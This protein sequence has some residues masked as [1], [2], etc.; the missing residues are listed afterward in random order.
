MLNTPIRFDPKPLPFYL[1][2]PTRAAEV[3]TP[4]WPRFTPESLSKNAAR[5]AGLPA[6]FPAHVEEALE[7]L[8]RSL[9]DDAHP[10][11]FGKANYSLLL[12]TG[13]CSFLQVEQAFRDNPSL[14]MTPLIPP[15]F[16]IGLPRSGTTFLHRLLSA[17]EDAAGVALYQHVYPVPGRF[18]DLRRADLRLQFEPWKRASRAYQM[19]AMHLVRPE[20]PDECNWGMR[21]GGRSMLFSSVAP[22]YG[23]L[24]WLLDQDLRETYAFYRKVL[25][26]HQHHMP[27]KRLVLKCPH[28]LAWL[29]ALAEAFPE[30]H[31]VETHRDPLETVP[32]ECKLNLSLH[33]L[34]APKLDLRRTVEHTLLKCRTF[35]ERSV[36]FAATPE[37]RRI[38]HVD[39]RLLVKDPVALA[40]DIYAA[41]QLP[42]TERHERTLRAFASAN[43]QHKHGRNS[44]QLE[45]FALDRAD[46]LETFRAYRERFVETL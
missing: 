4:D 24:R 3:L 28:H 34:A 9:R 16:V 20:L 31:I 44:Y 38:H 6:H 14:H 32:S 11:W 15:V 46:I 27:G 13:L 1:Q 8:C 21:L 23:Y 36:A 39:Y 40:R 5:A 22:V 26:L 41:L 2:I 43:K 37:G 29:P 17:S 35:A 33:C 12:G 30:A 18:F 10:H 25:L 19:D 42:F 45:Q 7:V